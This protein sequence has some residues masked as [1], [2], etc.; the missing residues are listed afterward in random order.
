[1]KDAN[2]E[3]LKPGD[4][5][6]IHPEWQDP[7]DDEFDRIVYEVT[8]EGASVMIWALIPGFEYPPTEWIQ[9][10]WL[11]RMADEE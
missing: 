11:I 1:M 3:S 10:N 7:G 9:A 2:G 5:V 6:R 8:K 4:L